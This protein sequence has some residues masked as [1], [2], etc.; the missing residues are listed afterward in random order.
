M[1][2]GKGQ[3]EEDTED[4]LGEKYVRQRKPDNLIEL[5]K[6]GEVLGKGGLDSV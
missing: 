4:R 5:Y 1:W 3:T 2:C 6:V